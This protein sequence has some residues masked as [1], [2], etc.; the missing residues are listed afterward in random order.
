MNKAYSFYPIDIKF[1][2]IKIMSCQSSRKQLLREGQKKRLGFTFY[3]GHT[4]L[5][6]NLSSNKPVT[7]LYYLTL[8]TSAN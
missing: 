3:T 6:G 8:S 4:V 7:L 1:R 2:G 5:L